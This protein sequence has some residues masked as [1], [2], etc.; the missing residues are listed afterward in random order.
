MAWGGKLRQFRVV[1]VAF[2]FALPAAVHAQEFPAPVNRDHTI[3]MHIGAAIG[4]ARI[5]GMGGTAVAIAEGSSGTVV[6]PAA[7][8]VRPTTS[9]DTWDWDWHF[10]SS[11][12]AIGDDFDNNGIKTT[13]TSFSPSFTGGLLG[14]YKNWGIGFSAV[15]QTSIT[16][17]AEGEKLDSQ[18]VVINLGLARSFLDDQLVIGAGIRGVE[19]TVDR[20]TI[21]SKDKLLKLTGVGVQTGA[22]WKPKNRSFRLGASFLSPI[23]SDQVEILGCDPLDCAGYILP[24]KVKVPWQLSLGVAQRRGPTRWN[25]TVQTPW[26]DEKALT[27]AADIV[28]TG[29]TNQG[30]GLEAFALHQL[31]PAGRTVSTSLRA[32]VEYDW[33]PGRFR[34]RGGSYWEGGR[35]RDAANKDID[36]RLHVT[37]GFDLRVWSF[38]FWGDPYRLRLSWTADA[39]EEFGNSAIS[40]GFWH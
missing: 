39:A 16:R 35:Y 32:G 1:S 34:V 9:S 31:Q 38:G 25:Q 23:V 5:I 19:F 4:S 11:S 27:W 15:E 3:D 14:Q 7:T 21:A 17:P 40:V 8:G 20:E 2:G 37:I 13:D 29:A 28:L 26:R 18:A 10:D 12:P 30:T 24:D 6:N 33:F 22:I 36:G